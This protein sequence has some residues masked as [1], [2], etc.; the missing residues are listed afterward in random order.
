MKRPHERDVFSIAVVVVA[1]DIAVGAVF[2]FAGR[3]SETV[4]D[5][6]AFA[7]F[8]PRTFDL[9]GGGRNAPVKTFGK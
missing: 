6:F 4:P 5:G 3:A 9:V 7:V 8:V 1:S 2:D